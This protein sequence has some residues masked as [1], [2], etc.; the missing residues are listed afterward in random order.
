MLFITFRDM[1]FRLF[2]S[3]VVY[4][5]IVPCNY[6]SQRHIIL[7]SCKVYVTRK[8]TPPVVRCW[9]YQWLVTLNIDNN[10]GRK[11]VSNMPSLSVFFMRKIEKVILIEYPLLMNNLYDTVLSCTTV[12]CWF[13][14]EGI[15]IP[16]LYDSYSTVP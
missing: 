2:L 7:H 6:V 14:D 10:F 13:R 15:R 1:D 4:I 9:Y 12:I 5:E 8:S 3:S 11:I 16:L